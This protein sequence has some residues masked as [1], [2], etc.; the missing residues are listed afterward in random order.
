MKKILALTLL[1]LLLCAMSVT[2]FAATVTLKDDYNQKKVFADIA[3]G[4]FTL[5]SYA[6]CGF[7]QPSGEKFVG[8]KIG[9]NEVYYKPG[10]KIAVSGEMNIGAYY[11]SDRLDIVEVKYV[12]NKYND[13]NLVGYYPVVK[14]TP[15][16]L[17][18]PFYCG[19]GDANTSSFEFDHWLVEGECVKGYED[20]GGEW[21]W[22]FARAIAAE[23][24]RGEM[25]AEEVITVQ[26]DV[27]ITAVWK[28]EDNT[29]GGQGGNAGSGQGGN[30]GGGQGGNAGGSQG[31]TGAAA[32][33]PSTGDN[34]LRIDFL[35][36]AMLVSLCG[37][38]LMAKKRIN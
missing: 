37:L 33:M 31:S 27:T 21:G 38:R 29:G 12:S 3:D 18:Y 14:D 5:P 34:S 36:V 35:F 8:W 17:L 7:T 1:C 15:M 24:F 25:K 23:M 4:Q 9:T 30:T 13:N 32:D 19:F 26:G 2:A 10:A 16:N 11:V 6:D 22:L 20:L 28:G